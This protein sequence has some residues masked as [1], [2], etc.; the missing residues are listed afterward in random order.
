MDASTAARSGNAV[1]SSA[2][3]PG[4][5]MPNPEAAGGRT[6]RRSNHSTTPIMLPC[7][8]RS[9]TARILTGISCPSLCRRKTFH[10]VQPAVAE[11]RL[12]GAGHAAQAGLFLLAVHQ[13]VLAA[14]APDDFLGRIP[15]DFLGAFAPQQDAPLQIHQADSRGQTFQ[16]CAVNLLVQHST[17]FPYPISA[18]GA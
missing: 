4:V 6:A 2:D 16:R 11:R 7:S 9:G 13:K 15:G 1:C 14:R 12:H 10:R 17:R 3:A 18:C 8:L 5:T